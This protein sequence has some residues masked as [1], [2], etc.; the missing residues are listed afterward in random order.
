M[1][2]LESF[3]AVATHVGVTLI[4]GEDQNHIWGGER[5]G[6][7][8]HDQHHREYEVEEGLL[9]RMVVVVNQSHDS[10]AGLSSD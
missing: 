8:G 5:S 4:V 2:R 9:S 6:V 1:R 10:R 3:C 7:R